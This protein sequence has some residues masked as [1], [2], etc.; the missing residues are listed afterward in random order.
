V[1]RGPD[2]RLVLAPGSGRRRH[3]GG[4]AQEGAVAR[5]LVEGP[6]ASQ[7]ILVEGSRGVPVDV[8]TTNQ[9]HAGPSAWPDLENDLKSLLTWT[10]VL[11]EGLKWWCRKTFGGQL[12]ISP[13]PAGCLLLCCGCIVL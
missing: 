6:W 8:L 7:I 10:C 12:E 4:A 1:R 2:S 13:S 3:V 5:R 11:H 9:G